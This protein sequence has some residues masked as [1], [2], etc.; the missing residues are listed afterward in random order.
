MIPRR[1]SGLISACCFVIAACLVAMFLVGCASPP[2]RPQ[3]KYDALKRA[4]DAGLLKGVL[5]AR[6][7]R[8]PEHPPIW[9]TGQDGKPVLA[10][11]PPLAPLVDPKTC[12]FLRAWHARDKAVLDAFLLEPS[13]LDIE[14]IVKLIGA[15]TL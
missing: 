2:G 5:D 14:E 11:V 10:A 13:S 7:G 8:G 1:A 12:A 3:V 4:Y 9:V 15:G 6:C